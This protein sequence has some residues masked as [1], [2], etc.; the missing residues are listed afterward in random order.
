MTRIARE[1]LA[2]LRGRK[3]ELTLEQQSGAAAVQRAHMVRSK[4]KRASERSLGVAWLGPEDVDAAQLDRKLGNVRCTLDALLEHGLGIVK[5][6][7]AAKN[8]C[9]LV[10]RGRE[11]GFAT[12]RALEP[13]DRLVSA[14]DVAKRQGI[15]RLE[16]RIGGVTRSLGERTDGLARTHLEQQG[17][18]KE[19]QRASVLRMTR[20]HI[21]RYP[22][23]FIQATAVEGRP[24]DPKGR[25]IRND[26]NSIG[27]LVVVHA[28]PKPFQAQA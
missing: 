15:V 24:A 2:E 13:V 17:D 28:R 3:L 19:V 23:C 14:S 10:E 6:A 16:H 22:L 12:H 27:I 4:R 21:A 11:S 8:K 1:H 25:L 20:E 9:K 18:A 5:A 26:R 7:H